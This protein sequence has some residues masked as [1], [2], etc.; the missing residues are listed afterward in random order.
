M[1][2][3]SEIRTFARETGLTVGKRGRLAPEVKSAY[4]HAHPSQARELAV[5]KGIAVSAKGRLS[6]ET[7]AQVIREIA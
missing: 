4:F 2:T 6:D 7:I 3:A 5:E 1:V